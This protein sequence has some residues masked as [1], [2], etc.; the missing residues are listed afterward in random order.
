VTLVVEL[1]Q[2]TDTRTIVDRLRSEFAGLE[3]IAQRQRRET[4]VTPTAVHDRLE[5]RLSDR[6]YEA[7]QTAHTM[8][9]FDWPRESSGEDVA[10]RLGITQ[11][12]VNK[13]IRLGER[14]VFDML[15]AAT[16]G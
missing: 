15:F 4:A 8:G 6:Q 5:Q 14:K 9:Y 1:P 13:H 16:S 3:L 2:E 7:L 11:P 12:T 10:E